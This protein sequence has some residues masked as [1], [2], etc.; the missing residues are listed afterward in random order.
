MEQAKKTTCLEKLNFMGGF[1]GISP[2]LCRQRD[3]SD[4]GTADLFTGELEV[5]ETVA[6]LAC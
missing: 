1:V 2:I 3:K 6:G 4:A 5:S